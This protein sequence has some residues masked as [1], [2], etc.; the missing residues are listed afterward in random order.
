VVELAFSGGSAGA[1]V[2]ATDAAAELSVAADPVAKHLNCIL[3][4]AT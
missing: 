1:A 2:A 3:I 4:D